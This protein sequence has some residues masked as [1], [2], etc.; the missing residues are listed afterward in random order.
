MR[1]SESQC[2]FSED[3]SHTNQYSIQHVHEVCF[4]LGLHVTNIVIVLSF[5]QYPFHSTLVPI[6]HITALLQYVESVMAGLSLKMEQEI[7]LNF[8][9]AIICPSFPFFVPKR[10]DCTLLIKILLDLISQLF[11]NV[12]FYFLSPVFA[13]L[14]LLF[15]ENKEIG[16]TTI[17]SPFLFFY[18]Y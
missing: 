18:S 5:Y 2:G 9:M 1:G 13:F 4:V 6:Y 16:Q 11:R 17:F 14:L 12:D 15:R 10:F 8:L 3:L 7:E